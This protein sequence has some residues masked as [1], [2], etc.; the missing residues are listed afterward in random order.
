MLRKC[1]LYQLWWEMLFCFSPP[2]LPE[3]RQFEKGSTTS[4]SCCRRTIPLTITSVRSRMLQ[5]ARITKG[6]Q[7]AWPAIAKCVDGLTCTVT[8]RV[9]RCAPTPT[10]MTVDRPWFRWP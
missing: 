4:S 10:W 5:P 6:M 7:R 9:C 3:R 1:T 8:N 2:T